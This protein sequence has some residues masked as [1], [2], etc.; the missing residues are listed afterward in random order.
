MSACLPVPT[1][2]FQ[3]Y[4]AEI[5]RI[6]VLSRE[7]E[8]ELAV[9]HYEKGDVEV[10]HRLALANLR[11]VVKVAHEYRAYGLRMADLVQE[12]NIGL[13]MAIKK[14][15]PYK[16][17][18]LISYAVWWI[19]AYI[20]NFILR[21]WSLVKIGTTQ[22]QRKLFYKLKESKRK[23]LGMLG[24]GDSGQI[25]D[26][27]GTQRV[28]KRLDLREEDVAMMD[29]RLSAR[30]V[31]LDT[32]VGDDPRTTYLERL[33]APATQ[34]ETVAKNETTALVNSK[35]KEALKTLRPRECFIVTQRVMS[36]SPMTLQEI[37]DHFGVS[38]ERARQLE[39]RAVKK[40]RKQ[41]ESLKEAA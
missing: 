6:P 16:G 5:S 21:S 1:S 11:F 32:P 29:A 20:Q 37:G 22:A 19:R 38:R 39:S 18:R 40:L 10:A 4:M 30:D 12:G 17:N 35:V 33:A 7:E 9:R 36:D 3:R 23:I 24:S 31:S 2:S 34:E 15:D 8:F 27:W 26:S 25:L 14:F 28:A 13:L 41:L